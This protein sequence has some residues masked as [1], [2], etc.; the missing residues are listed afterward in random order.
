MFRILRFF[1]LLIF[2]SVTFAEEPLPPDEAFQFSYKTKAPDKLLLS[3]NI[4]AGH[5]L[6]QQK[7]KFISLTPNIKI[8]MP[9]F[10]KGESKEDKTFGNVEI[11]RNDLELELSISSQHTELN[12]EVVFQGCADV[13]VCYLPIHKVFAVDLN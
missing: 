7:F 3:W 12:M 2:C 13:G 1:F 4:A 5:Y 8:G 6:Y 11:Y 9:N 10:P